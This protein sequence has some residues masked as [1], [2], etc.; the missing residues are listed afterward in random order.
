LGIEQGVLEDGGTLGVTGEHG[1]VQNRLG[2]LSGWDVDDV[3][4][5]RVGSQAGR[6]S[7]VRRGWSRRD[8]AAEAEE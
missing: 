4:Q 3:L 6:R 5:A 7:R 1:F 2:E 8:E